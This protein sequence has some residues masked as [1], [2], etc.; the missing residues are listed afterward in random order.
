[1]LLTSGAATIAGTL[2]LVAAVHTATLTPLLAAVVLAGAGQ[3]AGQLG[4]L[5][6]LSREVPAARRAEA[7]AGLNAGGYLLAGAL[8]V[9][10]GYLSDAIGLPAAAT[11]FGLV[12]SALAAAGAALV[13]VRG[14]DAG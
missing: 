3:G 10:D 4:G 9:A 1:V 11:V 8:P 2:A 13:A 7:N 6:L 14:M 5:T 12:V